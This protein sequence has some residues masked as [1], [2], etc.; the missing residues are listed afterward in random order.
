[1]FYLGRLSIYTFDCIY[2]INVN[3]CVWGVCTAVQLFEHTYG[4]EQVTEL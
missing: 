1:M 3:M 4:M 2:N